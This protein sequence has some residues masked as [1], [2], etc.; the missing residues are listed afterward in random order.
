MKAIWRELS[1]KTTSS[2]WHSWSN[3]TLE[4]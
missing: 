1:F 3:N 2:R 4:P